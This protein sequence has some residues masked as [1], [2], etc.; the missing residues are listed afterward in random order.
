MLGKEEHAR[1]DEEEAAE[2]ADALMNEPDAQVRGRVIR[3]VQANPA[4]NLSLMRFINAWNAV[5]E[6]LTRAA[7]AGMTTSALE[8]LV[9]P[10]EGEDEDSDPKLEGGALQAVG[11]GED[12][13]DG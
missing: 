7:E 2:W 1:I 11:G 12:R 6:V 13:A 3:N 4:T 5:A 10:L 9:P 8:K